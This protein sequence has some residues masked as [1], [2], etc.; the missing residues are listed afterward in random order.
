[1]ATLLAS[2][3][4]TGA[5]HPRGASASPEARRRPPPSEIAS[6]RQVPAALER[7]WLTEE[8]QHFAGRFTAKAS[9]CLVGVDPIRGQAQAAQVAAALER[10]ETHI[11]HEYRRLRLCL[12]VLAGQVECGSLIDQLKESLLLIAKAWGIKATVL[13]RGRLPLISDDS[14]WQ[15]LWVAFQWLS[16]R[17]QSG[18]PS[19]RAEVTERPGGLSIVMKDQGGTPVRPDID[20]SWPMVQA[21]DRMNSI[22]GSF[23]VLAMDGWTIARIDFPAIKGVE[24]EQE[25]S[26]PHS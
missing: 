19:L 22:G 5:P 9:R 10:L 7:R 2:Q 20:I 21:E 3:P 1:M 23:S 15:I 17:A 18:A 16:W 26:N 8:L 13:L 12:A 4:R 25:N 6:L 24:H 11:T 14:N